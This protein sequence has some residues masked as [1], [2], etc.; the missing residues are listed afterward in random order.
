MKHVSN[1]YTTLQ[2][3]FDK[4]S[5]FQCNNKYVFRSK[6]IENIKIRSRNN[7]IKTLL[8]ATK[9]GR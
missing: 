9:G 2:L 7:I 8:N 5:S 1:F 4:L 3:T 6:S